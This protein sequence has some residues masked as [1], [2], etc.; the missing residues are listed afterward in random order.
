MPKAF[1][2]LPKTFLVILLVN[3]TNFLLSS[4]LLNDN[5]ND[6]ADILYLAILLSYSF[7]VGNLIFLMTCFKM[8][9]QKKRLPFKIMTFIMKLT[10]FLD[11]CIFL[12]LEFNQNSDQWGII[13]TYSTIF[14][15]SEFFFQNL[16]IF[17][18]D[19]QTIKFF[20]SSILVLLNLIIMLV[21]MF[22]GWNP[23]IIILFLEFLSIIY[24][25]ETLRCCMHRL[26][27]EHKFLDMISKS[28]YSFNKF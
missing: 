18:S 21:I 26:K 9:E 10:P 23:F 17:N 11:M 4:F 12:N 20:I 25:L 3:I 1:C 24:L 22:I 8:P 15:V 28:K 27:K 19:K 16:L 5:S 7:L 2:R 14:R 6:L 13:L